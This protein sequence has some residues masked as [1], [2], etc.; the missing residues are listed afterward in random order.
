[1]TDTSH[2][3]N[4]SIIAHID[5]GK[6]TLADRLIQVC[7]GLTLRE[8][9]EQVLDSMEHRARARH[10]HQGPDRPARLHRQERRALRAQ[11]DR[12]AGPCRF[13]LRGQPVAGRLRGL[14]AG[15]RRQPGRRGADAGQRLSGHRR[16]PR[17]RPGAQ[18]DRSAGRRA[19]ARPPADRGRH[20]HRRLRRARDLGQDRRRAS[21]RC[22][23][24]S[25]TACRRRKGDERGAA[26]G[27]A[28]R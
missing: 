17:D 8:M 28:G 15:G 13:R 20:R 18:Q 2:I 24:P 11:P 22:W 26:Q 14:A 1:M 3:R 25:S 16:R 7:G 5:H 10:H 27:A 4:F 12:H 23:R 19:R 6:S 21:P 9:K